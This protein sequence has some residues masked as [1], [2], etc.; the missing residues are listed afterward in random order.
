[1]LPVAFIVQLGPLERVDLN[2]DTLVVDGSFAVA[3]TSDLEY[4]LEKATKGLF[5]SFTSG[6]GLVNTFRGTGSVLIAPVPNRFITLL[7]EFGG[8]RHLIR[9]ISKS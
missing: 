6:E 3:R 9:G 1:V 5:S 2:N 7:Q 8:L 4:G